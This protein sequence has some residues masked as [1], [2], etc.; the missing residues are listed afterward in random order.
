M[1]LPL[2]STQETVTIGAQ[3]NV[4][5]DSGDQLSKLLPILLLSGG[6]G[7]AS[8]G[9]GSGGLFGGGGD[10]GIGT[11]ALVLALAGK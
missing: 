6:F 10:G 3:P 9:S 2:L 4:V 7:G 11:I 1:L 8:G 5:I